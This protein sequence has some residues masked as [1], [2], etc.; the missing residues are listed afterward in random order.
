MVKC[1]YNYADENY[2]VTTDEGL[3]V[4]IGKTKEEAIENAE[5]LGLDC[6]NLEGDNLDD[7]L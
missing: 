2:W 3:V 6:N 4:G 5:F 7:L 1:Y